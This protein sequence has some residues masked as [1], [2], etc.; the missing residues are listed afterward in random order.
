MAHTI[1][2]PDVVASHPRLS[3]RTL[4]LGG[5]LAGPVFLISGFTQGLTREAFDFSRH[6]LSILAN[7]D[8]GWIQVTTF[9]I[10][11]L[12]TLAAAMGFRAAMPSGRG[13]TWVPRLMAIWALGQI[14]AGIF[15]AD[16]GLGFPSG[17]P[18]EQGTLSTAGILHMVFGQLAFISAIIVCFI[19]AR[20]F[21]AEGKRG[22]RL[23][24]LVTG[25]VFTAAIVGLST[26]G[27]TNP[28]ILTGFYAG[29]TLSFAWLT[30]LSLRFRGRRPAR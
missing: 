16:P 11:G 10:S 30:L 26:G 21:A 24:S 9:I 7:G 28:I 27:G 13:S 29:V 20:R 3:A 22:W 14:G 12:L 6:P 8:L 25:V 17:T 23:F 2:A 5:A 1:S 15:R 19:M 18:D 4:L